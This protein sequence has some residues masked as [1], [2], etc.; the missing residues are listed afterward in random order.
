M[1]N[2]INGVDDFTVCSLFA[3]KNFTNKRLDLHIFK[4]FS[5]NTYMGHSILLLRKG[6]EIKDG[7][8]VGIDTDS[9][10]Q[11]MLV[12]ECFKEVRVNY[13][14]VHYNNLFYMLEKGC[15]DATIWSGEDIKNFDGT[16]LNLPERM[17]ELVE[18]AGK[19][20]IIVT[21][22]NYEKMEIVESLFDISQ[23]ESVQ[24]SIINHK[25]VP[26]Y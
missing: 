23:I 22:K 18:D 1:D 10:D 20:A 11:E 3:A 7:I 9:F 14:Q 19:A 16:I 26:N 4:E 5:A 17:T 15:I 6:Q 24:K 8:T 2:V 12:R 25:G 21:E 13:E